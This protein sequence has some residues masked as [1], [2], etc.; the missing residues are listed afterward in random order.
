MTLELTLFVTSDTHG[1]WIE[2][3]D[4]D[5][6]SLKDTA[7]C[8][9]KLQAKCDHP[10]LTIDLGDFIQGSGLATY[11]AQIEENGDMFARAM[12]YLNYDYQLIGNHEF[13]F[14]NQY[15]DHILQQLKAKILAANTVDAISGQPIYGQPYDIIEI[16]GQMIGIIGLTTSYIKH[17]ELAQNYQGLDFPDAFD[18]A[19]KY[20]AE[21]R[22]RVDVLILAYHGGFE[23]DLV[24]FQPIEP[25]TGENQGARM[26]EEIPGI[27]VLLTGHQHREIAEIVR[28][29]AVVQPGFGGEWIGRID[30][31]I[32]HH[33]II[34]KSA[35]LIPISKA[36]EDDSNL[37][38]VL[39]PDYQQGR[40]WLHHV[41]G[42]ADIQSPTQDAFAARLYGHPYAELLNQLQLKETGAQ[43][44]GIA[45]VNDSF[46]DFVGPITNEKLLLSYPFY[47]LIAK[48]ALTGQDLKEI[49]EFNLK[50]FSFN[51]RGELRVNPRKLEPK[52][53]HYNYDLYSGFHCLVDL[54]QPIG[55]RVLEMTDEATGQ[56]IK[57]DQVYTVAVTQYRSVGGGNYHWFS[58]DK[59]LSL[60][61]ID[62]AKLIHQ[63]LE[64]YSASDWQAIN[65]NYRH[66]DFVEPYSLAKDPL[67]LDE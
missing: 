62:I 57:M 16:Q 37:M 59:V 19:K 3:P 23:K 26:L 21:L 41:I 33:R 39:N 18:T 38:A 54:K 52:P 42:S 64:N 49:M 30:L 11:Y 28:Q 63:A 55:Q 56:A 46:A 60:S 20:V 67:S 44:S 27:D 14:G 13:N 6:L 31:T 7:V 61:E 25:Q 22:P 53:Q 10:Y 4:A 5:N 17:W 40:Q 12:N 45:I 36:K 35:Q 48:V 34:D 43:F 32:D 47:N 29:V 65:Q 24:D 2:R 1:Q 50:Y 15:R 9:K 8:L 66:M 58:K 51:S